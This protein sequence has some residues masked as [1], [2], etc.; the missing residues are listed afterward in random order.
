MNDIDI[1]KAENKYLKELE[2][3]K[4][5]EIERLRKE[6][7]DLAEE[8]V[9]HLGTHQKIERLRKEKEWLIEQYIL[10]VHGHEQSTFEKIA[11]KKHMLKRM[12]QALGE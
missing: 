1:L 6:N 10:D 5:K 4:D 2:W 3:E 7:K 8:L 12:Q 9:Q 11:V